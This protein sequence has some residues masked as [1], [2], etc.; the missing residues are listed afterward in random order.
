MSAH[1]EKRKNTRKKTNN[2]YD[3]LSLY[4]KH[5]SKYSKSDTI[6]SEGLQF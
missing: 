5:E 1:L 3:R 6:F 4:Y 2:V